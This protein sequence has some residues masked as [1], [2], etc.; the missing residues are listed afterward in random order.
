MAVGL[1]MRGGS[2]VRLAGVDVDC[3]CSCSVGPVIVY[4][5]VFCYYLIIVLTSYVPCAVI[6]WL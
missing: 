4:V 5:A 1:A 2:A 3:V 6:L